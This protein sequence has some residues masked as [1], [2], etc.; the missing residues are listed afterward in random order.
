[1]PQRPS[2]PSLALLTSLAAACAA[3]ETPSASDTDPGTSTGA[4]ESTGDAPRQALYHEDVRP[5]LAQHCVGCHSEGAVAPFELDDYADVR[6]WG[7][8]VVASVEYR[9]MPPFAVANDGSCN[10]FLDARWLSDD[11]IDTIAAWADAGYPEGDASL[12]PPAAPE[13]PTLTGTVTT[14]SLPDYE[15]AIVDGHREEYRCFLV[16]L[17]LDAPRYVTGFDVHPGNPELVHHVLGFRVDPGILGNAAQMQALD[18]VSPDVPGWECYGAA[19]EDVI[20]GGVPV[21]WAPGAGATAYPDGVGV[22]FDPGDVLVVQV[23]YD[24]SH[25]SGRDATKVSLQLADEVEREA[26]QILWDPFLFTTQFGGEVPEL[27]PGQ[28]RT[29]YTWDDTLREMLSFDSGDPDFE[30]VEIVGL[31]PHMHQRGLRMSVE[32][33]TAEGTQCGADVDRWDFD[34]QRTYFYEQPISAS[35]DDVMKV[36]CEWS[37]LEDEVPVLPGF[38]TADEMCLVGLM[39]V[40]E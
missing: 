24:L 40:P 6:A 38:G 32:L 22:R 10:T 23:H 15:P 27:P 2:L 13:P 34:W 31:T 39:V 5:I 18:D 4:E 8:L 3:D 28:E 12:T 9:T 29:T 26:I 30:R 16:E 20:P 37:T 21:T 25:G 33:Q 35:L 17:D 1:M 7:E 36:T 11:E 14:L 19:G